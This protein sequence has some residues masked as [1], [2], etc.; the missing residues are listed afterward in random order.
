MP[1][2]KGNKYAS[3]TVDDMTA[4]IGLYLNHI[5]DGYSKKSFVDCDYRTIESHIEKDE[6]LYP[7]KRRKE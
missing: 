6:V 2:K 5:A 4:M 7:L 1:A 3:K